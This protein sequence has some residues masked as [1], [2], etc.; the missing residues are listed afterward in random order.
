MKLINGVEVLT[1]NAELLA[2]SRCALLVIDMQNENLSG[3]G[4]YAAVGT[5][6]VATQGAIKAISRLVRAARSAGVLV[7]YAEFIHRSATGVQ[8]ND[9]PNLYV[10]RNAEFVSEVR[11]GTWEAK[12][13]DEL[14]PQPADLVF[15]KTRSSAF[16][17]TLLADQ[18][19]NRSIHSVVVTGM[20]TQGCVLHTHADALMHG[21]Y[22]IVASDGVCTYEEEWHQL[23]MRWMARKSPVLEA[24]VIV[25]EWAA[26]GAA[27]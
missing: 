8:C 22:P 26:A 16:H 6:M 7:A 24:A 20:I 3:R 4:G 23:A 27:D 14:S 21:F 17:A 2:P 12:T 9:G 13:I 15:P 11:E 19:H 25:S 5:T 1:T 18:L 10:H